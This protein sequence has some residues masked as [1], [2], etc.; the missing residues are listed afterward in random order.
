MSHR[1]LV[2]V[3]VVVACVSPRPGLAE[4]TDRW[5]R[6]R[7]ALPVADSLE[8]SDC[9]TALTELREARTELI[10]GPSER[11]DEMVDA[12]IREAETVYFDCPPPEG[13]REAFTRL[14][15]MARQVDD[16]AGRG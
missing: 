2:V 16:A 9:Q 10:P 5:D 1:T 12:W 4:W 7:Q 13:F 8:K 15:Q 6:V 3:L 11:L 14:D